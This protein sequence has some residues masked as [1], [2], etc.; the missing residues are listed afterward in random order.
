M[1]RGLKQLFLW[2]FLISNLFCNFCLSGGATVWAVCVRE[3]Q[4]S[5]RTARVFLNIGPA[6][7]ISTSSTLQNCLLHCPQL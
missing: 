4:A 6:V 3:G 1:K 5:L 2:A 7:A